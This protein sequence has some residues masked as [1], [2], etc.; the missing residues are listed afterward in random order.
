MGMDALV[1]MVLNE[2]GIKPERFSLQWA[3]AA[4]APRFVKLITDFTQ[5]T[6]ELGPLGESEGIEPAELTARLEKALAVVS[7][8]KVRM[9]FANA[10]KG[11]RKEGNF[12]RE[13]ISQVIAEKLA[14]SL[15]K[16]FAPV[17]AGQEKKT[18]KPAP[19]K[20]EAAKKP[21]AGKKTGPA[22]AKKPVAKAAA[23][24][25]GAARKKT[26]AKKKKS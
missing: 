20:K 13:H 12:T 25:K 6:R 19:R 15:S 18:E 4:E 23:P 17:P 9:V 10:T 21:A 3:S 24:K 7:D 8:R 16:A 11:V 1:G 26:T 22:K 5:L 2:V 14:K